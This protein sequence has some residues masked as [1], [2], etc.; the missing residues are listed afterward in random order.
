[1]KGYVTDWTYYSCIAKFVYDDL[2]E[3]VNFCGKYW[4][5]NQTKNWYIAGQE[6]NKM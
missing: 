2:M 3:N 6:N 1:M 4:Q 5:N